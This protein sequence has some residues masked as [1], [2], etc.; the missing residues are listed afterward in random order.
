VNLIPFLISVTLVAAS[1]NCSNVMHLQ[2]FFFLQTLSFYCTLFLLS[3]WRVQVL[4]N[5]AIPDPETD[6]RCQTHGLR[7]VYST[8]R[9]PHAGAWYATKTRTGR[10]I[11]TWQL[12]KVFTAWP[13]A[14]AP[15]HHLLWESRAE[16][17]GQDP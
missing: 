16:Q 1:R 4:I 11:K 9:R 10:M 3:D 7:R 5:P 12:R 17:Q 13:F 8:A 15:T 14:A 6:P 2:M